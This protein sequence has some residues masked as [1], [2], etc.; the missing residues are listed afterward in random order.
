MEERS[1]SILPR[2]LLIHDRSRRNSIAPDGL[3]LHG[4]ILQLGDAAAA[5]PVGHTAA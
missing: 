1:P 3:G 2:A 5:L 4:K